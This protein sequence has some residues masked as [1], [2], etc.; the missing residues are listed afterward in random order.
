MS[1]RTD[2]DDL[3]CNLRNDVDTLIYELNVVL[4]ME[5]IDD[6]KAALQ[7]TINTAQTLREEL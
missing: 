2:I 5:N 1:Y 4:E 6:M 7:D 3:L